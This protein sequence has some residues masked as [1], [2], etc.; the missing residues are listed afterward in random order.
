MNGGKLPVFYLHRACSILAWQIQFLVIGFH[1]YAVTGRALDLGLLGL[2][3]FVPLMLSAPIGGQVADRFDRAKIITACSALGAVGSFGLA[4]S[5]YLAKTSV[6]PL[7]V[8]VAGLGAVRSFGAPAS[9]ALLPLLVDRP[10][11][12]RAAAISSTVWQLCMMI[13]PAVGGVL[14]GATGRADVVLLVSGVLGL[15]SLTVSL[16]LP[17]LGIAGEKKAISRE[18]LSM[19]LRFVFT[20]KLLLGAITLDLFAVLL[21]GATAL[22]P[23]VARDVLH[24]GPTG[25]GVLRAAPAVGAAL[26]AAVLARFPIERRAGKKLLWSV[27]GFGAAT[28]GFGLSTH[29]WLSVATLALAGAFD[30][31]SVVIR[32]VIVQL[33]TPDE[34]R[35]RVSSVNMVFIGA[36]NELGELE[37]GL[38]A[39]WLGAVPAI[40]AGGV[41]TMLVVGAVAVAF[42]KLR[43]T[44]RLTGT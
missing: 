5:V 25:L 27:L 1:V 8:I 39:A 37:S 24:T 15:C 34:M 22:L 28:V 38:A 14:L 42:P 21:G 17:R 7:F 18:A 20:E 32:Q 41:G 9:Q 23:V 16:A 43:A 31:I 10:G 11:L 44:D 3:Q 26:T 30:M 2:V 40:V 12:P 13:G 19:G 29:L 36:S 4:A 35:G 6:T 33:G